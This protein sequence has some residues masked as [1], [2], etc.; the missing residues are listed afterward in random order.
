MSYILGRDSQESRRLD[1]QHEFTRRW[2]HGRLIHPSILLT[3]L[4]AVADVGTGTGIWINEV[5][6]L[7][8]SQ[9][10]TSDFIGFDVSAEQFMPAAAR[11]PGVKFEVHDVFKPFA[12]KYRGKFDLV[13]VRYLAYGISEKSLPSIMNSLS[14]LLRPGGY[15][16]WQEVDIIDCWTNPSTESAREAISL[17]VAEKMECGIVLS[18]PSALMKAIL[19][20]STNLIEDGKLNTLSW[21]SDDLR[22][23]SLD[24]VSTVHHADP[25]VLE[26]KDAIGLAI[27]TLLL[28]GAARRN[29]VLASNKEQSS[30]ERE[31]RAKLGQKCED[32]AQAIQRETAEGQTSWDSLLTWVVARKANVLS[33]SEDWMKSYR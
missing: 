1:I 13:N 3:D 7:L 30:S 5:A 12:E 19:G 2:G 28:R 18:L 20:V 17:I 16:Q 15:L 8:N 9:D 27:N 26:H 4:H 32:N 21:N 23:W 31:K 22:V 14:E 10:R 11:V 24:T 29:R 33:K 25:F 6:E